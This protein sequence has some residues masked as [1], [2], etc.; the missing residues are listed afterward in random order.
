[1]AKSS[2]DYSDKFHTIRIRVEDYIS[3]LEIN[4]K[5]QIP[6]VGLVHFAIPMLKRKF[7]TMELP[8]GE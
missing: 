6:I 7:I 5:T 8:K 3:L 4:K 1:M 2:K